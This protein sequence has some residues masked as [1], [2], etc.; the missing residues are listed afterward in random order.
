MLEAIAYA[1]INLCLAVAAPE[2]RVLAD[3]TP[4]RRGGWHRIDSWF[5]CVGLGD[6]VRVRLT[7]NAGACRATI[8][9]EDP[10]LGV[11]DWPV[12]KDLAVRALRALAARVAERGAERGETSPGFELELI[13]R[14]PTG[15]GLGGGSSDA[16]AALLLANQQLQR[17]LPI[18][19]L[20]AIA[21]TIGSDVSFFIDETPR[22]GASRSAVV[23][24]F[25]DQIERVD[26]SV[27]G[28]VVLIL[29]P[30]ACPTPAVYKAFDQWL[31]Q[32]PRF[33]FRAGQAAALARSGAPAGS[34][35]TRLFND[36]AEPAMRVAPQLRDIHAACERVAAPVHVTGS[37]STL[38]VLTDPGSGERVAESLR[39]VLDARTRVM[40]TTLLG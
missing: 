30:L 10:A 22:G 34:L 38:F 2:A 33:V 26:S 16:A 31:E 3:G 21:G 32:K 25:G 37:G 9:F 36:L 17:P 13:K 20:R 35:S 5:R 6:V 23:S 29:P 39:R 28:D 15:G 24:G 40:A 27:D 12:E 14:V 4:N 7:G 1:K 18:D 19:E 8:R 11:V